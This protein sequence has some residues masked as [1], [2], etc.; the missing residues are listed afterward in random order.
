MHNTFAYKFKYT[1]L[2]ICLA[3]KA[4]ALCGSLSRRP[5]GVCTLQAAGRRTAGG[6]LHH[7]RASGGWLI[8]SAVAYFGEGINENVEVHADHA[9]IGG[10]LAGELC[11]CEPGRRNAKC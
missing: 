6:T 11:G 10:A 1:K 2:L 5:C 7:G 8:A 3:C 4:A 9:T